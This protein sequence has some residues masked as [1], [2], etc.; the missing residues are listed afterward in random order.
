V[1][2]NQRFK[3]TYRPPAGTRLNLGVGRN[4][5]QWLTPQ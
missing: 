1:L 5:E 3:P 4:S 2:P